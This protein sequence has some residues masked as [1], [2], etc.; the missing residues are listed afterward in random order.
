M[1][2][3]IPKGS[4]TFPT[5][6]DECRTERSVVAVGVTIERGL[7]AG[8]AKAEARKGEWAMFARGKIRKPLLE[9]SPG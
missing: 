2:L 3:R 1:T 5:N 4:S 9:H 8:K 7:V 6:L